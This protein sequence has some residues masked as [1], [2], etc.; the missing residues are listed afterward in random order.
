MIF[1]AKYAQPQIE[2]P[3]DLRAAGSGWAREEFYIPEEAIIFDKENPFPGGFANFEWN[4]TAEQLDSG[5]TIEFYYFQIALD[6]IPKSRRKIED[7]SEMA[8]SVEYSK[9]HRNLLEPRVFTKTPAKAHT[10]TVKT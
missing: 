8:K 2:I 6:K 9:L 4:L 3:R 5:N 10:I 1:S 7:L